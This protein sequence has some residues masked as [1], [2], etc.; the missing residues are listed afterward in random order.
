MS[1]DTKITATK[2]FV[3]T[4]DE[5]TLES[6]KTYAEGVG[7]SVT[8]E[9]KSYAYDTAKEALKQ[10][11]AYTD[12]NKPTKVSELEND[13]VYM[14]T[15]EVYGTPVY[16]VSY[17]ELG[18]TGVMANI[19]E[20]SEDG[21]KLYTYT[22]QIPGNNYMEAKVE[23]AKKDR[24]RYCGEVATVD[25]LP[26]NAASCDIYKV[27]ADGKRYIYWNNKW[28]AID[29]ID[30]SAYATQEWVQQNAVLPGNIHTFIHVAR[31]DTTGIVRPSKQKIEVPDHS[32]LWGHTFVNTS[33]TGEMRV[34]LSRS[35]LIGKDDTDI[36]IGSSAG[37]GNHGVAVGTAAYAN[38][39]NIAIGYNA[40]ARYYDYMYNKSSIAI[41]VGA[42]AG[43]GQ[44]AI[45]QTADKVM[46]N[47]Y[48]SGHDAISLVDVIKENAGGAKCFQHQFCGLSELNLVGK[49][50]CR[51]AT[52]DWQE[53][54]L[55]IKVEAFT[56]SGTEYIL[57]NPKKIY[58]EWNNTGRVIGLS[59]A[60]NNATTIAESR[61]LSDVEFTSGD[62][63]LIELIPVGYD[64]ETRNDT[65]MT[66]WTKLNQPY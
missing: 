35:K 37:A 56:G 23:E 19:P 29:N 26:K 14:T 58:I 28:Q 43:Q 12:E 4:K 21:K 16:N 11:K 64:W 65:W 55:T 3:N 32:F 34:A 41:G 48:G 42:Y 8:Q 33:N 2:E 54:N 57:P 62:K 15:K 13:G 39:Y 20:K 10:A 46:L 52:A 9:T 30:L 25:N 47:S 38:N 49:D 1:A 31:H 60:N 5:N 53:A 18:I 40:S 22:L 24:L 17:P 66:R 45:A 7:L 63:L 51:I 44:F 6:A 36:V 59:N 27:T 61:P 50:Y